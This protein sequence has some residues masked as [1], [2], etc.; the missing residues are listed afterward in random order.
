MSTATVTSKGQITIPADIREEMGIQPGAKVVFTRLPNGSTVMRVKSRSA[1]D[2][3]GMMKDR[4]PKGLKVS[5]EDMNLG[6][7]PA[8]A[9]LAPGQLVPVEKLSL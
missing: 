3:V 1:L 8:D 2:L 6:S 4:I 9:P 7:S 5:I